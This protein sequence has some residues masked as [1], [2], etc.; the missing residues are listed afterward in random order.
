MPP[1]RPPSSSP[2]KKSTAGGNTKLALPRKSVPAPLTRLKFI[3]Q[4]PPAADRRQ[5]PAS[6]AQAG[7]NRATTIKMASPSKRPAA[8]A[9]AADPSPSPS[10]ASS[11]LSPGGAAGLRKLRLLN[12][13][14]AD[15]PGAAAAAAA[16]ATAAAATTTGPPARPTPPSRLPLAACPLPPLP[17]AAYI[18]AGTRRIVSAPLAVPRA[19]PSLA[20]AA[21]ATATATATATAAAAPAAAPPRRRPRRP[22]P[23]FSRP[24]SGEGGRG[25]WP[26][27]SSSLPVPPRGPVGVALSEPLLHRLEMLAEEDLVPFVGEEEEDDDDD[28]DEDE[29]DEEG[30]GGVW[31]LPGG[32]ERA[33][34]PLPPLPTVLKKDE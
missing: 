10:S 18:P 11:A 6:L 1:S 19:R 7:P 3:P 24:L 4:R 12:A 20:A 23:N 16:A 5:L 31:P 13:S 26:Q 28:E 33:D 34:K 22:I 2:S 29:E 9:P 32:R 30:G 8:A 15:L 21:A 27:R 17:P 14:T 25:S